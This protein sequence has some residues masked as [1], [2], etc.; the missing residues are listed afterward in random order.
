MITRYGLEGPGVES[1][2]I[3][4]LGPHSILC[5]RNWVSFLDV[6]RQRRGLDHSPPSSAEDKESVELYL[7][8]LSLGIRGVLTGGSYLYLYLN[9]LLVLA[10]LHKQINIHE[11]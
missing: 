5:N 7:Y 4:A 6:K 3:P 11:L 8:S 2:P 10:L 1:R 9:R